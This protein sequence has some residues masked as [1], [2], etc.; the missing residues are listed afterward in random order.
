M[1]FYERTLELHLGAK[2][3][4][5]IQQSA[6]L[7]ADLGETECLRSKRNIRAIQKRDFLRSVLQAQRPPLRIPK[8]GTLTVFHRQM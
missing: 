5:V 4:A 3:E 7:V 1:E 8:S 2:F 6:Q